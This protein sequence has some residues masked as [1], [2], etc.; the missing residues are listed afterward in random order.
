M[1]LAF[2]V[3]GAN[4]ASAGLG[5]VTQSGNVPVEGISITGQSSV[6]GSA[7]AATY[8]ASFIPS[9]TTQRG[10]AWSIVSGNAAA[11]INASTGVLSVLPGAALASVTI[12]ATST[13]N[14]SV[15]ADKS[16]VVSYSGG[17]EFTP[18]E[19]LTAC[20]NFQRKDG[21]VDTD[22]VILPTD[23]VRCK[24]A[25][26]SPAGAIFGSRQSTSSDDNGTNLCVDSFGI[27]YRGLKAK[28]FGTLRVPADQIAYG[29]VYYV[30]I[31]A[32]TYDVTPS[33]GAISSSE[34]T[35]SESLPISIGSLKFANGSFGESFIGDVYGLE[36]LDE[37]DVVKHRLIPQSDL[38]FLDE[39]TQ[40]VY[41]C[42][43]TVVYR[44]N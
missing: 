44:Q 39:I 41:P 28:F 27:N 17:G 34:L 37:N 30:E 20:I 19:E 9:N 12:R 16:I 10:V 22:I 40:Q 32:N 5:K 21:H 26:G 3:N 13:D 25:L 31:D 24:F 7:D 2:I 33:L 6:A 1:G 14:P 18:I 42:V 15:T 38:T 29:T 8:I 43:G 36:I 35:Y 4:F 11:S 23:K